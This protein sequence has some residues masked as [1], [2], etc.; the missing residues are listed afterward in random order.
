MPVL[1][2]PPWSEV[3][4]EKEENKATDKN[5]KLIFIFVT[6]FWI[7]PD[8]FYKGRQPDSF[9]KTCFY[10]YRQIKKNIIVPKLFDISDHFLCH[11]RLD[12]DWSLLLT[13]RITLLPASLYVIVICHETNVALIT[14]RWQIKKQLLR[15]QIT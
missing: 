4:A 9:F 5:F 2:Y 14:L 7:A 8:H 1:R 11:H 13:N 6:G 12:I 3:E 10:C 15:L